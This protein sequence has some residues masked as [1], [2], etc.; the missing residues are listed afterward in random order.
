MFL[1]NQKTYPHKKPLRFLQ[2]TVTRGLDVPVK[3]DLADGAVAD[4][5]GARV[6]DGRDV[7]F[8]GGLDGGIFKCQ[9]SVSA[10]CAV[11]QYEVVAVA[12]RLGLCDVATDEAEVL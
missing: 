8:H 3:D 11:L 5:A 1:A 6:L 7:A 9:I 10:H 2:N 4:K 12:Q